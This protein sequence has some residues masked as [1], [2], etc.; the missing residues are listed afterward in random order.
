MELTKE[1]YQII[2]RAVGYYQ[3]HGAHLNRED[4]KNCSHVLEQI[5][6]LIYTQKQEQ[7]T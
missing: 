2:Y 5:F 3:I 6:P 7:P 1:E 4:Y